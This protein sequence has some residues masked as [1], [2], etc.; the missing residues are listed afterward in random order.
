MREFKRETNQI[1]KS[2]SY[3]GQNLQFWYRS[4][5]QRICY[6]GLSHDGWFLVHECGPSLPQFDETNAMPTLCQNDYMIQKP[7]GASLNNSNEIEYKNK[8]W[9]TNTY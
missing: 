4:G 3:Q 6:L 5:H 2:R 8:I 7:D 1:R 9:Q